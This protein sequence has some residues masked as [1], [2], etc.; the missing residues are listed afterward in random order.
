[1]TYDS[2]KAGKITG[3]LMRSPGPPAES[4]EACAKVNAKVSIKIHLLHANR[5][6]L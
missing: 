6:V 3:R 2:A 5:G 1:M 4:T